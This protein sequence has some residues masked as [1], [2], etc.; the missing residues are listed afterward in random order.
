MREARLVA[1][2]RFT[3]LPTMFVRA[4]TRQPLQN[5]AP[6]KGCYPIPSTQMAKS[7]AEAKA[8]P[9]AKA[10]AKAPSPKEKPATKATMA[11]KL[12]AAF[13]ARYS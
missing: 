13:E 1:A 11:A 5:F 10:G 2:S 12:R 6:R 3:L 7:K 9:K 4:N 8:A